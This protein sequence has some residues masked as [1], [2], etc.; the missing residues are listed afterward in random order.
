MLGGLRLGR[1]FGITGSSDSH[2][3]FAGDY[4]LMGVLVD[5][6]TREAVID[7][8]RSRRTYGTTG[9]RI[10]LSFTADGEPMGSILRGAG[11]VAA[12]P[13]VL[14]AAT[15][16]TAPLE[17]FALFENDRIVHRADADPSDP[18]RA[19]LEFTPAAPPPDGTWYQVR[20]RQQDGEVAWSTPIWIA[21]RPPALADA[22]TLLLKRRMAALLQAEYL[23]RWPHVPSPALGGKSPFDAAAEPA[24]R[25]KLVAAFAQYEKECLAF[26]RLALEIGLTREEAAAAHARFG[27]QFRRAPESLVDPTLRLEQVRARLGLAPDGQ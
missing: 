20:V 9:A 6:L 14:R 12:A 19:A 7:A 5:E 13:P 1:V 25:E 15:L 17:E 8:I 23:R 21:P 10:L 3:G 16:G 24:L 26:E 27:T 4:G 11:E 2:Y 22:E 18:R